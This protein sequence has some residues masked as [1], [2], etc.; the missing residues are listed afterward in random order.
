[1]TNFATIIC[2]QVCSYTFN[3]YFAK[4]CDKIEIFFGPV[5]DISLNKTA[6]CFILIV[7]TWI[8][9]RVVGIAPVYGLNEFESR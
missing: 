4:F 5:F 8:L 1:M 2:V 9:D 6:V 3:K 7:V